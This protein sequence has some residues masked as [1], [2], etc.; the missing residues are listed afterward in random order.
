MAEIRALSERVETVD[1]R[2]AES[3][4]T[5][6]AHE[7]LLQS[8]FAL[9]D[10]THAM[11]GRIT[12]QFE[13]E[14]ESDPESQD[15]AD[16]AEVAA[17]TLHQRRGLLVHAQPCEHWRL[18]ESCERLLRG[19]KKS[20][21]AVE[22]AL[23]R[24]AALPLR[25]NGRELEA[26]LSVRRRYAALRREIAQLAVPDADIAGRLGG[27]SK[28]IATLLR[29][30]EYASMRIGDRRELRMLQFRI[31]S[32][33]ST[34]HSSALMG[35]RLWEELQAVVNLLA[36]VN[37]RSELVT[38]DGDALAALRDVLLRS[39]DVNA[40]RAAAEPLFGLDAELDELL[41]LQRVGGH[42]PLRWESTVRRLLHEKGVWSSGPVAIPPQSDE[43]KA[44]SDAEASDPE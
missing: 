44:G 34:P 37:R 2:A 42:E 25:G 40:L 28:S 4:K 32:W 29:A 19:V 41:D 23:R 26:A 18:L 12:R 35:E 10:H 43:T 31:Q 1:L 14:Q 27:A 38:H 8:I 21:V 20:L 30:E 22:T 16:I 6:A 17:L 3:D 24:Y 11:A 13:G 7:A 9:A 15:V 39:G 33:L 36:A 5:E